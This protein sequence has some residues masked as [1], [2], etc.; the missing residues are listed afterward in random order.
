MELIKD[1]E[2]TLHGVEGNRF[3]GTEKVFDN[4]TLYPDMRCF[5]SDNVQLPSGVRNVSGCK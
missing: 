5:K 4:G 1:G 3:I 2:F